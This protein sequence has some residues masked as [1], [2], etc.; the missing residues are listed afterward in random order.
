MNNTRLQAAAKHFLQQH[1]KGFEDASLAEV[2]TRHSKAKLSEFAQQH[3][4]PD[5]T[6][7]D[8]EIIDAMVKLVSR[9]S[10]VS[11]FEKPKFRD[12]C[13][14]LDNMQAG[15]L[16]D[17]LMR[18]LHDDQAAGFDAMLSLLDTQKLAKWSLMTIIPSYYAPQ[19][20]V[21]VKPTTAKGIIAY[22]ELEGLAYKPRPSWA[23]YT[24]YRDWVNS[25]KQRVDPSLSPTNAAFT[26][27]LMMSLS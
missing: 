21:F 19:Y 26:G 16:A 17:S 4:A 25:A 27:F 18:F 14:R 13:Q 11:M 5:S 3:F 23:F 20:E 10:M 22:L 7:T 15:F 1:P 9:S 8:A 24:G 12:F 2:M 6:A